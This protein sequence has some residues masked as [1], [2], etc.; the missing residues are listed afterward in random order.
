MAMD[1]REAHYGYTDE[2]RID[3]MNLVQ[4]ASDAQ[5][6]ACLVPAEHADGAV[7]IAGAGYVR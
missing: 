4:Q 6:A 1:I 7:L 5:M 2:Q 3:G